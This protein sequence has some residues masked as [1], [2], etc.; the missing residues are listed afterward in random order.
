MRRAPHEHPIGTPVRS[1]NPKIGTTTATQTHV[2][3]GFANGRMAPRAAERSESFR[4]VPF[5]PRGYP[6]PRLSYVSCL[7]YRSFAHG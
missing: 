6:A 7:V 3:F 1:T 2:Q 5:K 4:V